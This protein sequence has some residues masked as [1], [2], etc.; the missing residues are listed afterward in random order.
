MAL[1]GRLGR[2]AIYGL[3]HAGDGASESCCRRRCWSDLA[4]ARCRCR[5]MLATMLLSHDGNVAVEV[6][7]SH[8][9]VGAE[10]CL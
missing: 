3:S 10:S 7:W 5:V 9:D 8:C 6:T 4:V 1:P 2:D